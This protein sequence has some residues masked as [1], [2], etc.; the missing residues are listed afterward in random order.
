VK[1][2]AIGRLQRAIAMVAAVGV[3][4]T[5]GYWLFGIS[6][7]DAAYQTVTTVTTVGFRELQ[8]FNNL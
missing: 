3:I 8:D 1:Y 4:G 5:V 2:T 7:T 6:L